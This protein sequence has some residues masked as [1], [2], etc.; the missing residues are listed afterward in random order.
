MHTL[1]A[2]LVLSLVP[3]LVPSLGSAAADTKPP[4][5]APR[6]A[7]VVAV[8]VADGATTVTV[9]LGAADGITADQKCAFFD[10]ANKKLAASC[11]ILRVDKHVTKL[12]TE[13]PVEQVSKPPL[14]VQ[15]GTDEALA[16]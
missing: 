13:L 1:V 10:P 9:A 3:S 2:A 11:A 12:R 14:S 4:A 7:R 8:Q 6:T 15:F 5:P 16:R